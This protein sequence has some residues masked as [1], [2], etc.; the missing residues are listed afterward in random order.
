MALE[1]KHVEICECCWHR[2]T[3]YTHTINKWLL[4]AFSQLVTFYRSH[5]KWANLQRDLLLTKNQYN[6][7][8]KLQY[9]QIV[10]R[11]NWRYPTELWLRFIDW[12]EAIY[13]T[14]ATF[15]KTVMPPIHKIRD[16]A[17]KKPKK[18]YPWDIDW[19][20]YKKRTEYQME[21]TPQLALF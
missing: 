6:N 1:M 9:L 14:V 5:K 12:E 4:S 19:E 10:K 18:V 3:C 20:Q 15:G 16:A 17:K 21:K 11:S 13:D 7:F 2:T 8:Q